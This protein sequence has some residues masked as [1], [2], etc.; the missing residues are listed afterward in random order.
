M[1]DDK[2][3]PQPTTQPPAT[4]AS[5]PSWKSLLKEIGVFILI[6]VCVV[7]P[8][9]MFIAEPYIVDGPSMD[10]TFKTGDYLIVDK[11]SYE[12]GNPQRNSVIIFKFP[13]NPSLSL[14]KRVIGLPGDT[15][16]VVNGAV[17]ITNTNNPAGFPLNESYLTHPQADNFTVTLGPDEYF[18]MGDN[19]PV[20]YDS[21][22]WGILPRKDIVGRPL[23]RLLPVTEIGALP[24]DH[25]ATSTQ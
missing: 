23:L 4:P 14:I 8:F 2:H 20:S 9:R 7:L 1:N 13:T 6:A 19:R 5:Q 22:S 17:T 10:P 16:T 24:G 11:L 12:L 3:S 21:R 18:V 15:V 25:T